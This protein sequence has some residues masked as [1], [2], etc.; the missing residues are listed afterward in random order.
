M[1][2]CEQC[3]RCCT[4][5]KDWDFAG[6]KFADA[7]IDRIA[8]HLGKTAEEFKSFYVVKNGYINIAKIGACPFLA[9]NRCT[10]YEVRPAYCAAWTCDG[11]HKS[12]GDY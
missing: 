8:R 5:D 11:T 2:E 6:V 12:V 7:D 9:N 1:F 10:I 4:A 3:G